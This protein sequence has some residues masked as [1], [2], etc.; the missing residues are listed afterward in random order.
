MV[1]CVAGLY[2]Q[3]K[4]VL[5]FDILWSFRWKTF[6]NKYIALM[7]AITVWVL[8]DFKFVFVFLYVCSF[9]CDLMWKNISF[10]RPLSK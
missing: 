8:K 5:L 6:Q 1:E 10:F 7:I 3:L 4:I 9:H 2:A